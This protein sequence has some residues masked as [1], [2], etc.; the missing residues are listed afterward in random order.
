MTK[1]TFKEDFKD[2][3]D[4]IQDI[5]D[6]FKSTPSSATPAVTS[7][8]EVSNKNIELLLRQST[9]MEYAISKGYTPTD[10]E[11]AWLGNAYELLLKTG[12][13]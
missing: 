8:A 10:D 2:V 13:I 12:N 3:T 9:D 4:D 5:I 7:C 1:K 6:D 11:Q